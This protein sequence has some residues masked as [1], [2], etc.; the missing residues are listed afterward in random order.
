MAQSAN[1]PFTT[2]DDKKKLEKIK[3]IKSRMTASGNVQYSDIQVHFFLLPR[4]M[5][6]TI[7]H[8]DQKL[9]T[10]KEITN[11]IGICHG[12]GSHADQ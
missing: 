11:G 6:D 5:L 2:G 8:W 1:T 10:T 7:K 3:T 12:I 4:L 9:S